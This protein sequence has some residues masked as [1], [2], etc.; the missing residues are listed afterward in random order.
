MITPRFNLYQN[1]NSLTIKIRAPYCCLRELDI[2]GHKDRFLFLCKPYY[3][4]LQLPGNIVEND[5]FHS[6]FDCDSGEFAFTYDKETPGEFFQD[7]DYITK[8]LVTKVDAIYE[9]NVTQ[10]IT[11][12]SADLTAQ[13]EE[14][15]NETLQQGFGFALQ[16]HKK[17]STISSEFSEV[18]EID[19]CEVGLVD[20]RKIRLQYEQGK[21]NMEHYLEDLQDEQ[22]EIKSITELKTPWDNLSEA[23]ITFTDKE[24]DFLKDQ[25]NNSYNLTTLQARYAFNGL[26]DI[27][28]AYCYDKRTTDYEGN[29]ESGWTIV[30]LASTLSWFDAFES[31][32]EALVSAFRRSVT[33]P[34]YRQFS[35]SVQVFEDLKKLLK[36]D[37]KML[38]KTLIEIHRIFL[39]GDYCR[40][41]LNNLFIKDYITYIMKW[42]KTKWRQYLEDVYSVEIQKEDLGLNLVEVERSFSLET[43]LAGLKISEDREVLDSDDTSDDSD[44]DSDTE[45]SSDETSSDESRVE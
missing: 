4:R 24:L 21:F 34:L 32:K 36:F 15:I 13:E 1:D 14:L 12:L 3:L 9:E 39:T 40:Y 37:E 23:D 10:P 26:L 38:I 41:I 20:R 17:F 28:Y 8:F 6:S 30:K 18:F 33:Y 29:S 19:P 35:L 5:N 22:Q 44:S 31:P 11:V 27:L 7:L 43:S 2:E 45:T 25:P 42:D 16:G